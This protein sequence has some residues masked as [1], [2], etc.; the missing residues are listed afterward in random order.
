M[1]GELQIKIIE[2]VYDLHLAGG[3]CNM[4]FLFPYIRNFIIPIDELIFFRGGKT[5]NQMII[6]LTIGL[7]Y[8]RQ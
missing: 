5:T 3:D 1:V 2:I 8:H 6:L 7:L 4:T